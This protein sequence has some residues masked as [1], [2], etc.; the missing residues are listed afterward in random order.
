[1]DIFTILKPPN[2]V[3]FLLFILLMDKSR[4]NAVGIATVCRL[5]D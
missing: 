2:V 5:D 1:M 4:V 3:G